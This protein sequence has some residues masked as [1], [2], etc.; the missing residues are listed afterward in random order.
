KWESPHNPAYVIYTSGSTG[1]PKGV[2]VTHDGTPSF[3]GA[4]IAQFAVT[5]EA[6]VLQFASLS[7]DAALWEIAMALGSGATLVLST[8]EERHGD[9]LAQLIRSRGVT[10]ALLP[11]A[12]LASL[13]EDLPL[14]SLA[15]GGEPCSADL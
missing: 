15:V 8:A 12:V 5:P 3:A 2:V 10:H 6:R 4:L 11:P 1:T 13:P 14:E 7:F 9:A